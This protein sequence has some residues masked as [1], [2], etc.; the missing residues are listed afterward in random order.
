MTNDVCCAVCDG[1]IQWDGTTTRMMMMM[2]R[3]DV[4]H[5]MYL[6]QWVLASRCHVFSLLK[7]NSNFLITNY[8]PIIL[9]ES[10][11]NAVCMY[12]N[13]LHFIIILILLNII[14]WIYDVAVIGQHDCRCVLC[15]KFIHRVVR[16][17]PQIFFSYLGLSLIYDC[18]D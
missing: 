4:W 3:P 13:V 1:G 18:F 8:W 16:I 15:V 14:V 12:A 11:L 7:K 10:R 6:S 5:H 2:I 9:F 17:G